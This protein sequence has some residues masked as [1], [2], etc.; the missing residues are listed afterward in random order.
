M[1]LCKLHLFAF[2][3]FILLP[4]FSYAQKFNIAGGVTGSVG[5][6]F[7]D[8][9]VNS[10][11]SNYELDRGVFASVSGERGFNVLNL[12]AVLGLSYLKT[13]GNANYDYT[14]LNGVNY[15]GLNLDFNAEIFQA[16][17]GLKFKLIDDYWF[18]PYVE[19]GG[20]F[21]YYKVTYESSDVQAKVTP[22]PP[23]TEELP[24][25]DSMADFGY[26]GEGGLEVA[27]SD[28]FGI[29]VAARLVKSE[30]QKIKTLG[31]E[32]VQYDSHIYYFS[33]LSTF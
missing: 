11:S 8:F 15:S 29:R 30:T 12:Y 25:A 7:A 17:L 6:G 1:K 14:N 31:N 23:A 26:Y 22:A 4:S 27:F 3:A 21:G 13:T 19:G 5:A 33:L 10:P 20:T 9:V 24:V 16:S 32:K 28:R 18:R 2:T